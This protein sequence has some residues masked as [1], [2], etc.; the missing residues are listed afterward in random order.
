MCD[1]YAAFIKEAKLSI[2]RSKRL[3]I[4]I[5]VMGLLKTTKSCA[6]ST[7]STGGRLNI[8]RTGTSYLGKYD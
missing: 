3:V 6:G 7:I 8:P 5:S 4:E 2:N 1:K